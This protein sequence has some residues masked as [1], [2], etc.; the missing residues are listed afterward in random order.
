[1]TVLYLLIP[2]GILIIA[3]AV[4]AFFWAVG[5]GQFDDLESPAWRILMDDD[6]KP[7]SGSRAPRPGGE[8]K[9]ENDDGS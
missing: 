9:T 6:S 2:L 7:P 5:S 3:V 4:W 1:M 8:K